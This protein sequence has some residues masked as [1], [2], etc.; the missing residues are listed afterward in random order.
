MEDDKNLAWLHYS[1]WFWYFCTVGEVWLPPLLFC[2]ARV[3]GETEE[4]AVAR[5]W[6]GWHL[7]SQFYTWRS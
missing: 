4:A 6:E 7:N 3:T 2:L 5:L 1:V